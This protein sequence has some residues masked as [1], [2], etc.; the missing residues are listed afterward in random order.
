MWDNTADNQRFIDA[1]KERGEAVLMYLDPKDGE[2]IIV[3]GSE[4]SI[5]L[6]GKIID[7]YDSAEMLAS[8]S[9][10]EERI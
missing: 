3:S 6:L 9:L 10:E 8:Y 7:A 5:A 4:Q 2:T 1:A